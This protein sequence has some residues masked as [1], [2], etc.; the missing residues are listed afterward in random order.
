MSTGGGNESSR[1]R[2]LARASSGEAFARSARN[3]VGLL[4]VK[5]Q[6]GPPPPKTRGGKNSR[7]CNTIANCIPPTPTVTD[8]SISISGASGTGGGYRITTTVSRQLTTT[9]GGDNNSGITGVNGGFQQFGRAAGGSRPP[10]PAASGQRPTPSSAG[11]IDNPRTATSAFN[12]QPV[13][14]AATTTADA[15]CQHRDNIA[16][17]ST[18]AKHVSQGQRAAGGAL[19][20]RQPSPAPVEQPGRR[21][22]QQRQPIANVADEFR[23][24]SVEALAAATADRGRMRLLPYVIV[25]GANSSIERQ[26]ARQR[27]TTRANITEAAS[28]GSALDNIGRP[29]AASLA[30]GQPG[31]H[32]HQRDFTEAS[33]SPV[34]N[35]SSDDFTL[36]RTGSR[37][38][39]DLQRPRPE[40]NTGASVHQSTVT[41]ITGKRLHQGRPESQIPTSSIPGPT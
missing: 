29:S 21:R 27:W 23:E 1:H 8:A 13:P 39:D 26:G 10:I 30:R 28:L 41:G 12:G 18:S 40:R 20:S 22:Q 14:A 16:P 31:V 11:S 33:T 35:I 15:P 24:L 34:A 37:E 2:Q 4:R 9:A 17:R 7:T 38:A 36:A 32:Q 3:N 19:G 25:A 5:L 6:D